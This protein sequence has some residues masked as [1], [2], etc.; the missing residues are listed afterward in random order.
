MSSP[1]ISIERLAALFPFSVA[2][3]RDLRILQVGASLASVGTKMG[4]GRPMT[5]CFRILR[6]DLPFTLETIKAN[7]RSIFVV[8]QVGGGLQLRGQMVWLEPDGP[9]LLLASPWI[10]DVTDLARFGLSIDDFA[11]HDATPDYL[12][13]LQGKNT[14]LQ[15]AKALSERLTQ[16]RTELRHTVD[17]LTEAAIQ[18]QRAKA[19]LASNEANLRAILDTA[20]DGILTIDDRGT[21]KTFN[22][23]ASRMFGWSAEEVTGQNV[24]VL[25]APPHRDAH[26]AYLAR[27]LETG[28]SRIIGIGREVEGVRKDGSRF[29]LHL[30]V[31]GVTTSEGRSFT[32]ILRDLVHASE[33]GTAAAQPVPSRLR[34]S[35]SP[36]V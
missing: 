25:A 31:S 32:G 27:H 5:E 36:R 34:M 14:A 22:A 6:P 15:D 35:P 9:G 11:I 7:L 21:I 33:P 20:A 1:G 19:A 12:F 3:D 23:A 17:A 16:Q 18:H 24:S 30:S 2:F 10:Q 29:P 8:E 13:L 4:P 28:E 26:D